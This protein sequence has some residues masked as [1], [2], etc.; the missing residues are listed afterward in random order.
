MMKIPGSGSA[1]GSIRQMHGSVDPDPHQNVM[2]PQHWMK[3][4]E[5]VAGK[6]WCRSSLADF[7][8]ARPFSQF[9]SDTRFLRVDKMSKYVNEDAHYFRLLLSIISAAQCN[10]LDIILTVGSPNHRVLVSSPAHTSVVDPECFFRIR[11]LLFGLFRILHKFV[12]IFLT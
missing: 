6:R 5:R 2:G 4:T 9:S 11:I 12:L 10:W 7:Y 1:S 8:R 3:H